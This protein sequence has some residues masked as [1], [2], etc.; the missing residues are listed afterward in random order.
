MD[1]PVPPMPMPPGTYRFSVD[2]F[3]IGFAT[4]FAPDVFSE[5]VFGPEFEAA[6]DVFTDLGTP[7]IPPLPPFAIPPANTG[8]V[9]GNGL[10]K[11]TGV[12][13]PGFGVFEPLF[14]GVPP[15]VG[16]NVDAYDEVVPGTTAAF[17]VYYSLDP[18]WPDPING[19]PHWGTGPALGFSSADVLV[20]PAPYAGPF[21]FAPA[22]LLGL[23]FFGFSSDDLDALALFEN[24]TGVYEPSLVPYDWVGGATDM[25]LFSVRRGSAVI[26]LPDSI[27][28]LPIEPGD[29]LTTPLAGGASPFPGI[30]IAAEN[31]GLMARA[32]ESFSDDIDALDVVLAPLLDCNGNGMEDA[33]DIAFGTSTDINM[34]GIPDECEIIAGPYCFCVVGICG[35]PDPGAGCANTTGMGAPLGYSGTTSV[36]NDDLFLAMSNLPPNKFG[37]LYMG[38]TTPMLPFGD[39]YRC[40]GGMVFRYPVI[41]SGPGGAIS[42]GPIVGHANTNFPPAGNIAAG[43]SWNFQ[44]WYRDPMGPCGSGWNLSNAV[45]FTFTP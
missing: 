20:T 45:T 31:L 44:G 40:V 29:I 19:F 23:D 5:G 11:T 3:A 36:A 43:A 33:V 6:G 18:P 4:P 41:N 13:Y 34:N 26:G 14:P 30:F 37:L 35:N 38:T 28:G 21:P 42:F 16:D 2:E 7:V 17:P 12:A 24:G 27:F 39:G 32:G 25:L 9:D 8:V 15:D 1:G 10:P 22:F